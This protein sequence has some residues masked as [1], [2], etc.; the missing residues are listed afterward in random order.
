[1]ADVAA[2]V[3]EHS[4]QTHPVSASSLLIVVGEPWSNQHQHLI[5]EQLTTG[6]HWSVFVTTHGMMACIVIFNVWIV[7]V[8]ELYKEFVT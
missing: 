2:D 8:F 7:T 4:R 6:R 1:M 5:I 3:D